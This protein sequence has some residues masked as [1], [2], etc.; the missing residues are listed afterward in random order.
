VVTVQE[1]AGEE[2]LNE[3]SSREKLLNRVAWVAYYN[4][5]VYEGCTRFVVHALQSHLHLASS[6]SAYL[7]SINP[8]LDADERR[9]FGLRI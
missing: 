1:R 4:D 8:I 9:F 7:D 5:R 2:V 3:P 6:A